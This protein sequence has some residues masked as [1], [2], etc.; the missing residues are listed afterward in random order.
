MNL[1]EEILIRLILRTALDLDTRWEDICEDLEMK[2]EE[3]S[4]QFR[5]LKDSGFVE[6]FGM[7]NL[8][9]KGRKK[10]Y[11]LLVKKICDKRVE[12]R[13]VP[14]ATEQMR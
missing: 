1:S 3:S 5:Q 6:Y 14:L 7:W 8:T 4:E 10:G 2:I 12:F 13:R 9:P 11:S